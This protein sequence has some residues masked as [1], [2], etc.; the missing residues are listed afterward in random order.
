MRT[1]N[2]LQLSCSGKRVLV[3]IRLISR[4]A[5]NGR[6]VKLTTY[7]FIL[8]WVV[9]IT[10]QYC[11]AATQAPP[12]TNDSANLTIAERT[13]LRGKELYE[14]GEFANA[15]RYFNVVL[16]L[17]DAHAF[18]RQYAELAQQQL[19]LLKD[20]LYRQWRA[21]FDARQFDRAAATYAR[22][23]SDKEPG[24]VQLAAQIEAQYQK[25]LSSLVNSWQAAC[26][27][28][29][30]QKSDSIRNEA[31]N[32][33]PG[34]PFGRDALAQ[35]R[36]CGSA[37]SVSDAAAN[38]AIVSNL[39]AS[40]SVVP[41]NNPG[42]SANGAITPPARKAAP[43]IRID[44]MLAM[45]QIMFRAKP[46]IEPDLQRYVGRGIVVSIEIDDKGNVSVKQVAKA[47]VRIA[48]ALK[49]A[50][51]E[52]KFRPLVVDDQPRCVDT[53]LPITLIQP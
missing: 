14:K 46:Q 8:F 26:A 45:K 7:K 3:P 31:A 38:P 51:E 34:L 9:T 35:I 37:S 41:A 25:A 4:D 23:R 22:I 13:F 15:L 43:C 24:A 29:D 19:E 50:V 44:P 28:R 18:A 32:I 17:D 12:P 5:A 27:A 30:L 39:P 48:D 36:Q 2:V 49:I 40:S 6:N 42:A 16:A 33:A 52:W 21:N 11:V 1:G 10:G 53:D 20:P 47:N